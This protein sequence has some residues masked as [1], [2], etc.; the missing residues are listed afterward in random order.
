MRWLRDENLGIVINFI[1][2]CWNNPG[3]F[4]PAKIRYLDA[5]FSP[6]C[7]SSPISRV[8]EHFCISFYSRENRIGQ[9]TVQNCKFCP[10]SSVKKTWNGLIP[11]WEFEKSLLSLSIETLQRLLFKPFFFLHRGAW[12]ITLWWSNP[13]WA[14]EGTRIGREWNLKKTEFVFLGSPMFYFFFP[15]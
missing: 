14:A 9:S 11:L 1:R 2:G 15:S 12:Y 10:S 13:F 5:D 7:S 6:S 3:L 4:L 8:G